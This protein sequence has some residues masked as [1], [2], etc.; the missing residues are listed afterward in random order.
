[1]VVVGLVG[2]IEN[3]QGLRSLTTIWAEHLSQRASYPRKK[4]R[5]RGRK[6]MGQ[7]GAKLGQ[8]TFHKLIQGHGNGEHSGEKPHSRGL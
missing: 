8:K 1:M 4:E 6:E 5:Q 7:L 3:S 2:Y